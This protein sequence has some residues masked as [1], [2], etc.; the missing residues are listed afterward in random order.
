MAIDQEKLKARRQRQNEARKQRR[1]N[2]Q[3]N[4]AELA[5]SVIPIVAPSFLGIHRTFANKEELRALYGDSFDSTR[6]IE[7]NRELHK[8]SAYLAAEARAT[9]R[10]IDRKRWSHA[11]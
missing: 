6:V 8:T 10:A 3:I 5:V 2:K 11:L 9:E 7:H 4:A 1:I